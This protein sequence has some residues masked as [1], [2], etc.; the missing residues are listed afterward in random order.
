MTFLLSGVVASAIVTIHR[1]EQLGQPAWL[2]ILNMIWLAMAIVW[3]L[4]M[5]VQLWFIISWPG[6]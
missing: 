6:D 5:A 2:H 1:H 4:W 3:L